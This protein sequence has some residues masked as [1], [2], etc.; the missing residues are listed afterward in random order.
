[1]DAEDRR[2]EAMWAMVFN[3]PGYWRNLDNEENYKYGKEDA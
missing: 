2:D 3:D 1:M